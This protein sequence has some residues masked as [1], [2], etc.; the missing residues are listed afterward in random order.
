MRNLLIT[1]E[2]TGTACVIDIDKSQSPSTMAALERVLPARISFNT[3]GEELYSDPLP[4]EVKEENA[5][6][7]VPLGAAAVWPPG[8]TLCLF[9]GKTPISMSNKIRPA[10]PVNIIGQLEPWPKD[11]IRRLGKTPVATVRIE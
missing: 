5:R 6:E 11:L 2:E 3:W 8:S 10:S 4:L 7:I 9:F 1:F